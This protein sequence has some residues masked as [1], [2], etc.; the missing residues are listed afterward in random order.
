MSS[1]INENAIQKYTF[2]RNEWM[3]IFLITFAI[4]GLFTPIYYAPFSALFMVFLKFI[5]YPG[6]ILY[7]CMS[8]K[9]VIR[10]HPD[11]LQKGSITPSRVNWKDIVAIQQGM[12]T[13]HYHG[14][15]YPFL[16]DSYL[17]LHNLP[18]FKVFLE[19]YAQK[20]DTLSTLSYSES[21]DSIIE[22]IHRDIQTHDHTSSFLHRIKPMAILIIGL[23]FLFVMNL[24]DTA[25][26]IYS[27]Y[28]DNFWILPL[29]S[30]LAFIIVGMIFLLYFRKAWVAP[31][32]KG[33]LFVYPLINGL[34]YIGI[35]ELIGDP[36]LHIF[37]ALSIMSL[38]AALLLF[39]R[40]DAAFNLIILPKKKQQ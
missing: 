11:Y 23:L 28:N 16:L 33:F 19:N 26:G 27:F 34:L 17:P 21:P 2:H 30:I 31:L 5:V 8:A 25:G 10:I 39:I 37:P 32:I 6:V 13:K 14:T 35:D 15:S 22:K 40:S 24:V 3:T 9:M 18:L 36:F 1:P 12:K 20:I 7:A 38:C 29:R 4:S